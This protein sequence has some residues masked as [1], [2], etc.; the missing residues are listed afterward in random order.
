MGR[1]VSHVPE[2]TTK[3]TPHA[4]LRERRRREEALRRHRADARVKQVADADELGYLREQL[5]VATSLTARL[6]ATNDLLEMAQLV[7]DELHETFA[8]YL[9]AVQRIDEDGVLRL[10]AGR[11]PLAEVM[12]EFL[13]TEQSLQ[14]GVNGRV[15]RSGLTALVPDTRADPDY[16]VRDPNTDPGSEL[17]VPVMLDGSVWGGAQHRGGRG[18]CPR[19]GRGGP[20]G[21]DRRKLRGRPASSPPHR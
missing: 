17:S 12:A 7:V 2:L 3:P 10:I 16:V 20:R 13:L 18:A 4:G 9:A 8:F 1:F 5:R 15:A 14:E 11:G 21:V 6:A 19:R